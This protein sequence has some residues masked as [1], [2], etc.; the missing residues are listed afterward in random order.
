MAIGFVWLGVIAAASL[1]ALWNR[2]QYADVQA[3][4]WVYLAL[5]SVPGIVLALALIRAPLI[6]GA[7]AVASAVWSAMNA[8]NTMRDTSSTAALGLLATPIIGLV[9]VVVGCVVDG[10]ARTRRT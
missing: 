9:I 4:A 2:P 8:W 6:L 7:T 10:A 5:F 3:S 1:A